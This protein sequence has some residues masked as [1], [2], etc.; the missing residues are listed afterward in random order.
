LLAEHERN[1]EAAYAQPGFAQLFARFDALSD[2]EPDPDE[3]DAIAREIVATVREQ[4]AE[5]DRGRGDTSLRTER[6]V[7]DWTTNLPP[8][9]RRLIERVVELGSQAA[10]EAAEESVQ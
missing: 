5:L 8:A 2:G 1:A 4:T 9:Q 7:A 10:E 3:L 6:L